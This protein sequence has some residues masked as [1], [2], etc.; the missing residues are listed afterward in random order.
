[1]SYTYHRPQPVV[2]IV[3]DLPPFAQTHGKVQMGKSERREARHI[4][5]ICVSGNI[6]RSPTPAWLS[7]VQHS[8]VHASFPLTILLCMCVVWM[9]ATAMCCCHTPGIRTAADSAQSLDILGFPSCDMLHDTTW[10]LIC[11]LM[12]LEHHLYL[13]WVWALPL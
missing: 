7:S 8:S 6:L 3:F 10:C 5:R 1:M 12:Q 13:I 2:L 9:H 4:H 11:K